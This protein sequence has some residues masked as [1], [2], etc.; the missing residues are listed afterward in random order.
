V[1][2]TERG[3][4]ISAFARTQRFDRHTIR[5]RCL[6]S[7]VR[8]CAL[9]HDSYHNSPNEAHGGACYKHR[10]SLRRSLG[11]ATPGSGPAMRPIL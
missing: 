10:G 2:E 4:N 1:L 9:V 7:D 11:V 6:R 3:K 5:A 8:I